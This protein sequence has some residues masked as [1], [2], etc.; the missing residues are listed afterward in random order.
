MGER[1]CLKKHDKLRI[2]KE[3]FLC[4]ALRYVLS[5]K[6][7]EPSL[8][9]HY[10]RFQIVLRV[11]FEDMLR[12]KLCFYFHWLWLKDIYTWRISTRFEKATKYQYGRQRLLV[13]CIYVEVARL[14]DIYSVWNVY[15][16]G[17]H[18]A[19]MVTD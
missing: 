14:W 4:T 10:C 5:P 2:N 8:L 9:Y 15:V 7:W 11:K 13:L 6:T 12:L 1:L 17:Y 3:M 18:S 19:F 16:C